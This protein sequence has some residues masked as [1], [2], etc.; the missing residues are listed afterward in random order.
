MFNLFKKH[1]VKT[2][3]VLIIAIILVCSAIIVSMSSMAYIFSERY[4]NQSTEDLLNDPYVNNQLQEAEYEQTIKELLADVS[5]NPNP[6][7]KLISEKLM[8]INVPRNLREQHF[9]LFVAFEEMAK[10]DKKDPA[11]VDEQLKWIKTQSG[12]LSEILSQFILHNL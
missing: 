10:G 3:K 11:L 5:S 2:H 8:E 4:Y 9:K 6:D 12:W 1:Q 7:Y